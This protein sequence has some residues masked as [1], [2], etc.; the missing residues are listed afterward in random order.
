[1]SPAG[2]PC[3]PNL[4]ALSVRP[5]GLDLIALSHLAE[6]GTP[7]GGNL[8]LIRELEQRTGVKMA[9]LEKNPTAYEYS[10]LLTEIAKVGCPILMI[11]GK[12]DNNAPLPVME[13]YVA[14]LCAE[15]KQ[16]D[17]YHPDN[18]PHGFYVGLPRLIPET[19]ESTRRA[20]AFIKR[21]F[22]KETDIGSASLS[23]DPAEETAIA[24]EVSRL[25]IPAI[26]TPK[27]KQP[28]FIVRA[29]GVQVYKA[30]AKLDWEFQAPSA[31]LR[32]YRTGEPVGT[33]S[34]GPVWIDAKGSKLTGKVLASAPAPNPQA[35]PWLLL[36]V[37]NSNGG[38]YAKVTHIQ[39]VDTW[40]GLKPAAAPANA[41]QSVEVPYQA[42]YVF[43]GDR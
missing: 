28:L 20:V 37:S 34:K 21:H 40:A 42:T 2:W 12:N 13:A 3:A 19:A 38:R 36:E 24:K 10:S 22:S 5:A 27:A 14:K 29:D 6:K 39:R 32:D 7:V 18:G 16:A 30:G 4:R 43:W 17:A 25:A 26:L 31:T 33:H 35:V 11:S 41:G 23:A 8:K 15:G 9:E 1:M